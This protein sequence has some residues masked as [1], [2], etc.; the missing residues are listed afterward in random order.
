MKRL[1]C[2]LWIDLNLLGPFLG[3][4]AGALSALNRFATRLE[5][6]GTSA[7]T[8]FCRS[9][10]IQVTVVLKDILAPF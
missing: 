9:A 10:D 8:G 3:M 5:K 7:V 6:R 1:K 4:A 2:V